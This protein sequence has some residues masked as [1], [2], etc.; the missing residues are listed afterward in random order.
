MI[1]SADHW[2]NTF[3]IHRNGQRSGE[4]YY[5]KYR[6]IGNKVYKLSSDLIT[7]KYVYAIFNCPLICDSRNALNIVKDDLIVKVDELAGEIEI[8]REELNAVNQSR[9]KL[10]Q[11]LSEV[12]DEL[13]KTKDQAK[14]QS[15]CS[16]YAAE[17][18]EQ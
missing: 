6:T 7:T 18:S 17:H 16:D 12:E 5:G 15:K 9:N 14:Q 10:R 1:L 13:K 11:K 3:F 8:I 2:N 4:S